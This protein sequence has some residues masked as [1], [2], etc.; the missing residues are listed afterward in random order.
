MNMYAF[1]E[2]QKYVAQQLGVEV[3][4]YIHIADSYHVYERDWKWFK[5]FVEHIESG[6]S[7]KRWRT[8]EEYMKMVQAT[9]RKTQSI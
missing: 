4:R 5:T 2:L 7:K 8:T 6:E 3:G 9:E 1:T